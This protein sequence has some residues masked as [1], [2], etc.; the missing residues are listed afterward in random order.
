VG[1]VCIA[2]TFTHY[3]K[4][5][6]AQHPPPPNGT[7]CPTVVYLKGGAFGATVAMAVVY[8]IL[9]FAMAIHFSYRKNISVVLRKRTCL[10]M[11]ISMIG[12]LFLYIAAIISLLIPTMPCYIR[13]AFDHRKF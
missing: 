6:M 2:S 13:A 8:P 11:M 10:L 1:V 9:I 12:A 4:R 7:R 5:E 3:L